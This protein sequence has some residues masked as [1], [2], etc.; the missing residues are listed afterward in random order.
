MKILTNNPLIRDQM[1]YDK[2]EIEY[3][4]IDYIDILYRGRD[5]IHRNKRLLTHP[6]YGSVKPNE[7]V[8]RTLVLTDSK[9]LD[10]ESLRYMEE[11]IQT[12]ETFLKNSDPKDWPERILNDFQVI[13]YD[14]IDHAV[15]RMIL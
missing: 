13:D 7:T 4:D 9:D 6:L 15:Q 12:A 1:D 14:L 5:E 8:Y 3:L 2:F 10:F 11:A